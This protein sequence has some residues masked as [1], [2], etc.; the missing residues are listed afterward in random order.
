MVEVSPVII[1]RFQ[2][3]ESVRCWCVCNDKKVPQDT[4]RP[5]PLRWIEERGKLL[6]LR[7]LVEVTPKYDGYG[8]IIGER[9]DNM[10]RCMDLDHALMNGIPKNKEIISFIES[11]LTFVEISSSGAGLHLFFEYPTRF[12]EFGLRSDFCEGKF[13]PSRFIKL[14]GNVYQ[15]HDY[16][17]YH[18]TDRELDNIRSVLSE[19]RP[20]YT[21]RNPTISCGSYATWDEIL[22]SAGIIHRP[23]AYSGKERHGHIAL[24][25]WKIPCPNR[26][27]HSDHGRP[28]DFSA[29]AAIL[30]RWNDGSSS[31]TC[32]HNACK[33]ETRPNLLRLL[34]QEIKAPQI[35]EGRRLL[36]KMGVI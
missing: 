32:N 14:T 26:K 27:K 9:G 17:I 25:T 12:E 5:G 28:G 24:E 20:Q 23:V 29:D 18:L 16:M 30:I 33:P 22:N 1:N 35:E 3:W 2:P 34:W 8:L 10:L 6:T 36:R 7:E 11:A 13:Y 21:P 4:T 31:L 19:N 15:D